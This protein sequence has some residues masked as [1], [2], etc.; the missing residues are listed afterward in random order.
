MAWQKPKTDWVA[1]DFFNCYDYNRWKNNIIYLKE[2]SSSVYPN[3]NLIDMGNDKSYSDIPYADE[4]NTLEENL[5]RVCNATYPF[6]FGEKQTFADNMPIID[7]EEMNRIE[8]A[9]ETI[10]E[11]LIGQLSG[12]HHLSFV[13]GRK[14]IGNREI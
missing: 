13:L 14:P 4:F 3:I 12:L 11:A 8:S 2:L 6:S 9:M 1:N 5:E 7:F 10:Y